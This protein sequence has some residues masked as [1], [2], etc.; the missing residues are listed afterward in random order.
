VCRGC[1]VRACGAHPLGHTRA[2]DYSTTTICASRPTSSNR[3][4]GLSSSRYGRAAT[5]AMTVGACYQPSPMPRE[6]HLCEDDS[7]ASAFHSPGRGVFVAHETA[8]TWPTACRA[9]AARCDA[10]RVRRLERGADDLSSQESGP[11]I[12]REDA[13][14]VQPDEGVLLDAKLG[15][16][17]IRMQLVET[18]RDFRPYAQAV[19]R[20]PRWGCDR[21]SRTMPWRGRRGPDRRSSPPE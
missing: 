8:S 13:D 20:R 18:D 4:G 14:L 9:C 16:R 21:R 17:P 15:E 6:A 1:R 10:R 5:R 3:F 2:R 11:V 7:L 19:A 12:V